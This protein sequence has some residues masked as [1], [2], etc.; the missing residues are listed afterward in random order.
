MF[1]ERVITE[2]LMLNKF[3][4]NFIP[5]E[6]WSCFSEGWKA[7]NLFT[8]PFP[9]LRTDLQDCNF[10][11][12]NNCWKS[13]QRLCGR[14][15]SD[16]AGTAAGSSL[17]NLQDPSAQLQLTPKLHQGCRQPHTKA[18][19]W[20]RHAARLKS[21]KYYTKGKN[22]LQISTCTSLEIWVF[23]LFLTTKKNI[24]HMTFILIVLF[25]K[26]FYCM[27]QSMLL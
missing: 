7:R 25:L 16:P 21:G 6:P 8:S 15:L 12:L 18:V 13:L 3:L 5:D 4:L 1:V 14:T 2:Q 19:C 11:A 20:T 22:R 10:F 26:V 23:K 17:L 9:T 27:L 24:P